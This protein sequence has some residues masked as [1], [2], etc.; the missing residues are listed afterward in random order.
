LYVQA[1]GNVGIGTT[2][3][4]ATLQVAGNVKLNLPGAGTGYALCHTTQSGT[5]SEEIVDCTSAPS[6]DYAEMYP[7]EE[8]I[9]PG[10]LVAPSNVIV[11]TTNGKKL[12]KLTKTTQPYQSTMI[13]VVSDPKDITDFNVIGFNIK[14]E[15]NPMPVALSG[16]VL[17]KVSTENGE[18]KPGDLL[19]SASS[20]PGV[21]MRATE[22]GRVI[23][24]ALEGYKG[25]GIGKITVFVNP[26]FWLGPIFEKST[27]TEQL[28][29]FDKFTLAIKRALEKLGLIIEN[30]IAQIKEIITEKLSAKVVV[31]NQLCLG[32]TCID[33]AKLKEL[34]ERSGTM[35]ATNNQPANNGAASN[36]TTSNEQLGSE[37][38]SI[39]SSSTSTATSTEETS[40]KI[41]TSTNEQLSSEQQTTNNQ[42]TNSE[43]FSTTASS[44]SSTV[45]IT[46][47]S[48]E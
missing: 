40:Q 19:T 41:S 42:T 5:T 27:T 10:D 35:G 15:D 44:T 4:S 36:G 8:G 48:S 9:E 47:P 34:L 39:N 21:A 24:I 20:T 2:A 31:T 12:T 14:D 43:Q 46:A 17:V 13:G 23:G 18:I 26:H 16:R 1:D 6:A 37:Q 38:S 3:P 32:Q 30:G 22:P 28:G 11:E 45:T 29:I 7:V 33:E 25:E